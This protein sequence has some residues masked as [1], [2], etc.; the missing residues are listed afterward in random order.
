MQQNLGSIIE[1]LSGENNI[2]GKYLDKRAFGKKLKT[3]ERKRV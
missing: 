3:Y 1:T 2:L